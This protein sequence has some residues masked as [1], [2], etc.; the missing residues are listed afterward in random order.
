VLVHVVAVHM[1]QVAVVQVVDMVAM[2]HSRMPAR[3]SVGMS[4]IFV[5]GAGTGAHGGLLA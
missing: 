5:L 4:V 3:G 2:M 1:M